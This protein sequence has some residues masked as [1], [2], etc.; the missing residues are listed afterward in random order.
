MTPRPSLKPAVVKELR[1]SWPV[2]A[3]ALTAMLASPLLAGGYFRGAGILAYTVGAASLGALAFGHEFSSGT[4]QS[5]L[6][7]PR[8][9]RATASIKIAVLLVSLLLLALAGHLVTFRPLGAVPADESTFLFW[10]PLATAVGLAPWLTLSLRS[11]TAGM[12]FSLAMPGFMFT[13]AL[14]TWLATRGFTPV[15]Q[16]FVFRVGWVGTLLVSSAGVFLGWR[17]FQRL[18]VDGGSELG[19][20]R[21]RRADP[22]PRLPLHARRFHPLW[23]LVRKELELQ[24]MT[25]IIAGAYLVGV[26]IVI[27]IRPVP[28]D[29]VQGVTLLYVAFLPSM[30]GALAS[31]EEHQLGTIEWQ[32]TLPMA[33]WK[34]WIVKVGVVL[35][36]AGFLAL[37]LPGALGLLPDR[38]LLARLGVAV[39]M[40]AAGSLY[41][42]SASH[43][44]L[45]ALL[46]AI[47]AMVVAAALAARVALSLYPQPA[48]LPS[49]GLRLIMT[50]AVAGAVLTLA[51]RN[52]QTVRA[53]GWPVGRQAAAAVTCA[54]CTALALTLMA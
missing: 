38:V 23:L 48:N 27:L 41:V 29:A 25:F 4:M 37:G 32:M 43:S 13:G 42:S 19:W 5:L 14:L 10:L 47:F 40:L 54:V 49:V 53:A 45:W 20:W 44:S 24:R 22:A 34:Q 11:A 50:V 28:D 17:A 12:A 16:S 52:H 51:K 39:L 31:A 33:S 21:W 18:E 30:P 8:S 26:M 6:A 35:G 36:V 7:L 3:S 1:A 46:T 15:P 2:L 9:R